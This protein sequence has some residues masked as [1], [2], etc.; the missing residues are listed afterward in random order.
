M[1]KSWREKLTEIGGYEN[2]L[3]S[4]P[5]GSVV[6]II[7]ELEVCREESSRLAKRIVGLEQDVREA[8]EMMD[9]I[10]EGR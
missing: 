5:A 10:E 9:S 6:K 8:N 4:V 7:E 1:S 2:E 3:L